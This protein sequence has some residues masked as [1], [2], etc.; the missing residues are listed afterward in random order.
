MGAAAGGGAHGGGPQAARCGPG[1]HSSRRAGREVGCPCCQAPRASLPPRLCGARLQVEALLYA[2]RCRRAS[3]AGAGARPGLTPQD[4][5][6]LFSE[7]VGSGPAW[8]SPGGGCMAAGPHPAA[9]CALSGAAPPHTACA[10]GRLPGGPA[11]LAAL[12]RPP[13]P[14]LCSRA[15]Q[16]AAPGAARRWRWRRWR[17]R[18]VAAQPRRAAAVLPAAQL[19]G[20]RAA[21]AACLGQRCAGSA[22]SRGAAVGAGAPAA[23]QGALG[24]G[25]GGPRLRCAAAALVLQN[26]A[27]A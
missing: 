14:G 22:H 9:A 18:G 2:D 10:V 25:G 8:P 21:P 17:Q 24:L 23:V 20:G 12:R 19:P 11:G 27:Q 15:E 3:A 5:Q 26:S 7:Q 13:A 16:L 1:T 6:E 4:E